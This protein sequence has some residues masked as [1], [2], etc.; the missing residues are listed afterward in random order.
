M[1]LTRAA[2][3]VSLALLAA[4]ATAPQGEESEHAA[5]DLSAGPAASTKPLCTPVERTIFSC[6]TTNDKLIAVC[7]SSDLSATTG[8]IQYRFGSDDAT[9]LKLPQDE[10]VQNFRQILRAYTTDPEVS[11]SFYASGL[12]LSKGSYTY[13]V[14]YSIGHGQE[15]AGVMV[16]KDGDELADI[17]CNDDYSNGIDIDT[18]LAAGVR[19]SLAD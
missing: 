17:R 9:E 13:T 10:A 15:S 14:H 18:V 8:Y 5:A 3:V 12:E 2:L 7:A 19:H 6:R 4:C 1:L 11:G 16:T